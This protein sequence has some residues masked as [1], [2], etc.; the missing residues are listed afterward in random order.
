MQA[1]GANLENMDLDLNMEDA[2]LDM[3]A[4][5]YV[6][7]GVL[8]GMRLNADVDWDVAADGIFGNI[9]VSATTMLKCTDYGTT[10]IERPNVD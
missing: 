10:V 4:E 1:L 3:F 2:K 6:S 7:D 5:Y 8:S 9:K